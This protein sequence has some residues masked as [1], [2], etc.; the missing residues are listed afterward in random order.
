VVP[1]ILR[2]LKENT[3]LRVSFARDAVTFSHAGL[4]DYSALF[5]TG[6]TAFTWSKEDVQ[7]LRGYLKKGGF[8]L[9]ESCCGNAAFDRSFRDFMRDVFPDSKLSVLPLD[10]RVYTFGRDPRAIQY[11]EIVKKENPDLTGPSLEGVTLD[12]TTA[13][14]YSKFALGC[15][16]EDH[17]CVECRGYTRAGAFDLV[18][19]VLLAGLTE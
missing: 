19:R 4:F 15:S 3:R 7:N 16:I 2:H 18:T 12:G 9:A 11:R 8:L 10:H 13:V 1:N 5:V 6:H 14:F 17:P